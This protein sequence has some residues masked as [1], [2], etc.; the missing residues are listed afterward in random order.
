MI[1]IRCTYPPA[2][3]GQTAGSHW[4]RRAKLIAQWRTLW[5]WEFYRYRLALQGQAR[6][7]ISFAPPDKLRRDLHNCQGA[8]KAGID[9]LADIVGVDDSKFR[10]EWS[11]DW[12]PSMAG[13]AVFIEFEPTP[14]KATE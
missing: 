14:Q 1:Q 6:F 4:R 11:P 8:F 12:L 2:K 13:G 9:A 7:K 3:L 10:I 5:S